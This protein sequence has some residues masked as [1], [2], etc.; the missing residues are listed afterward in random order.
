MVSFNKIKNQ[1]DILLQAFYGGYNKPISF[2]DKLPEFGTF[3][4]LL[5]SANPAE[6]FYISP[7]AIEN[8]KCLFYC[9]IT[10]KFLTYSHWLPIPKI[11]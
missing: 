8:D 11:K 2:K 6:I 7:S 9:E 1:F 4:L 5:D 10:R 3:I